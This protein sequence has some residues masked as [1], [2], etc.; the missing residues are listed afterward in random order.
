MTETGSTC[1]RVIHRARSGSRL[2][3][4]S[5]MPITANSTA[6]GAAATSAIR[7]AS[8]L[9]GTEC[10]RRPNSEAS[11][12]CIFRHSSK[13]RCV[14]GSQGTTANRA[15]TSRYCRII[16]SVWTGSQTRLTT[17]GL[18]AVRLR[19]GPATMRIRTGRRCPVA[20]KRQ[21][22]DYPGEKRMRRTGKKASSPPAGSSWSAG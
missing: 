1:E 20:G 6:V 18:R 12:R 4:T 19:P 11:P 13:R 16:A 15:G 7:R 21:P 2:L 17:T 14:A 5:G 9:A 8:C 3:C 10:C 22:V